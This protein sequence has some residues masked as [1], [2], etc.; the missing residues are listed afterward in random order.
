M[1]SNPRGCPGYGASAGNK[2]KDDSEE[3]HRG[4]GEID[5]GGKMARVNEIFSVCKFKASG[6][7]LFFSTRDS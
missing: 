5:T 2:G 1:V 7:I 3:L 4:G 6:E